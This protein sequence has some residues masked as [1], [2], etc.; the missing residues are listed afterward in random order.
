MAEW[1]QRI[2]WAIAWP[3]LV[4]IWLTSPALA[5]WIIS[6]IITLTMRPFTLANLFLTLRQQRRYR[7]NPTALHH[8]LRNSLSRWIRRGARHLCKST[9][10]ALRHLPTESGR[11]GALVC[12]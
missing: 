7:H 1:L 12:A 9:A 6:T 11:S 8:H 5:Y 3:W 2:F 4:C 10:R